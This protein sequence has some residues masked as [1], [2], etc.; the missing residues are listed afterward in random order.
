MLLMQTSKR[1]FRIPETQ[2]SRK[3]VSGEA[4]RA[5][6]SRYTAVRT[7]GVSGMAKSECQC[8]LTQKMELKNFGTE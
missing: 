7:H 2:S 1:W 6:A 5:K 8:W 3:G 4:T